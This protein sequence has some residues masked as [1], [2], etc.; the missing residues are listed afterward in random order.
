MEKEAKQ[1]LRAKS[2]KIGRSFRLLVVGDHGEII[3]FGRIK[4]LLVCLLATLI[5]SFAAA[6]VLGFLYLKQKSRIDLVKEQLSAAQKLSAGLRDERDVLMARLVIAESSFKPK[7]SPTPPSPPPKTLPE[8][9]PEP[10]PPAAQEV[11]SVKK[12][13]E[14]PAWELSRLSTI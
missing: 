1:R 6:C 9:K 2:H 12:T 7:V 13:G 11:E 8:V 14:Q 3:P 4:G 5:V 10:A